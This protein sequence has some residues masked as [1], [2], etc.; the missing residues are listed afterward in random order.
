MICG[1]A[2]CPACQHGDNRVFLCEQHAEVNVIQGW[3]Q[4]YSTTRE[5]DG[6][7]LCENLVADGIPARIF[8]QRD[9]MFSV[10]VGDLGLVRLL[11][12]VW[13]Y[14]EAIRTLRGYMDDRGEVRFACPS[15]GG[16]WDPAASSCP[17]CGATIPASAKD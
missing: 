17:T 15:C 13:E 9:H 10:D 12:P 11:V 4:I 2:L 6:Q 5:L 16:A 1:Q 3:A 8:S 7:L 14:E